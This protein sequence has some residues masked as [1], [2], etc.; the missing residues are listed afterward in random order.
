LTEKPKKRKENK[1]KRAG[2]PMDTPPNKTQFIKFCIVGVSGTFIDFTLLNILLT[3]NVSLPV[4]GS[5]SF[6]AAVINN[7]LWNKLWTFQNAPKKNNALQLAQFALISTLGLAIRIPTLYLGSLTPTTPLES[8]GV[9][10]EAAKTILYNLT[11]ALAIT[12][13]LT[14]NYFANKAWTFKLNNQIAKKTI[15]EKAC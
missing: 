14:W 8:L 13:T 10:P 4:A 6:I 12:I 1:P 9:S 2:K 3:Q 5:A 7:Y 15:N 11:A